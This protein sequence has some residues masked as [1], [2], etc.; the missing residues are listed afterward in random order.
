MYFEKYTNKIKKFE[1]IVLQLSLINLSIEKVGSY[2]RVKEKNFCRRKGLFSRKS[3]NRSNE[4]KR[5]KNKEIKR[6]RRT[7]STNAEG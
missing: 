6:N 1:A 2:K 7:S 4:E 5:E 3:V